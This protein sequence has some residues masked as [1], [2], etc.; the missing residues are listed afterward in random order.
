MDRFKSAGI[1]LLATIALLAAVL[2]LSEARPAVM[3]VEYRQNALRTIKVVDISRNLFDAL[4]SLRV[5]RGTVNTALVSPSPGTPGDFGTIRSLRASSTKSL[6]R[7]MAGLSALDDAGYAG[8]ARDTLQS[9]E[10]FQKLRNN[11]DSALHMFRR[12][13]PGRLA[14]DWVAAS[15]K[16]VDAIENLTVRLSRRIDRDDSF[17]S[18]MMRLAQFSWSTRA[19]AGNDRLLL[20]QALAEKKRLSV[21]DQMQIARFNAQVATSWMLIERQTRQADA[22]PLIRA[23]ASRADKLYFGDFLRVRAAVVAALV[24]NGTSPVSTHAWLAASDPALKS[25]MQVADAAFVVARSYCEERIDRSRTESLTSMV[26]VTLIVAMIAM[27]WMFVLTHIIRPLAEIT[28]TT[29]LMA[30][31]NLDQTIPYSRRKDEIG[32]LA[33]A[34]AV[35]R[36]LAIEQRNLERNLVIARQEAD[37][38]SRAK[39]RF[40]ANMTHEL[41]TPLNAVIGFSDMIIAEV[42]GPIQNERYRGYLADIHKSGMHLL[43]LINDVLDWSRLDSG[44]SDLHE[45]TVELASLVDEALNVVAPMADKA[46]V[47]LS[48]EFDVALPGVRVD[49][50][51]M[52]QVLLNLLSNA[53]KFTPAGGSVRAIL[54]RI[55]DGLRIRISDTGIG[56]AK[57]N[58]A[59]VFERFG[60]VEDGLTRKYDGTGLGIPIAKAL[61]ELHGGTFS[62][63]SELHAGTTATIVLPAS[64]VVPTLIVSAA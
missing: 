29:H 44:T 57:E 25:L 26:L 24:K 43:A 62:L 13:R 64:R 45:E 54:D 56:I 14:S 33:A 58:M 11:V 50:R 9:V 63:E 15:D 49:Q 8:V 51:R 53:I 28:R 5:E 42:H 32:R 52:H 2:M 23:A 60:Q 38:S 34:L 19:A 18:Q 20:G 39:S 41:R 12:Q 46:G 4:Q 21:A 55:D 61:V 35:F 30:A 10:R 17:V 40:L 16:L 36:D 59:R 22:P 31:G 48:R 47:R 27:A 37:L 3:A 7:A 6:N 1:P